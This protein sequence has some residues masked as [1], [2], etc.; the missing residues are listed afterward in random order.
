MTPRRL[1]SCFKCGK[2]SYAKWRICSD[3]KWHGIC[4]EHDIELNAIGMRWAFGDTREAD[5]ASY[6]EKVRKEAQE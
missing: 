1:Q 2:P 6:A 4:A 5:I 3:G